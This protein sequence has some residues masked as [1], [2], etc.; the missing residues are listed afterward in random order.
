MPVIKVN[1]GTVVSSFS[2]LPLGS[3]LGEI[4]KV[5][6]LAPRQ[7]GKF[8]QLLISYLVIDGDLTGR[9]QS[10]FLSLS[11]NAMGFVKDFFEKFGL[12]EI[13]D[14]VIDDDSEEL[15]DPDLVGAQVIFKNSQDKKDP[16]RVRV[17]LTSVE[18]WAGS[19]PTVAPTRSAVK[20]PKPLPNQI[21]APDAAAAKAA[22]KAARIAAAEAA[23]AAAAEDDD[24]DEPEAVVEEAPAAKPAAARPATTAAPVRRTL[25]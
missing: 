12:G 19:E 4:T 15:T 20:P 25:R 24:D 9:R 1:L 10:Q 13:P 5:K 7:A 2:D 16:D 6:L 23:L 8:A 14:L 17:T 22:A 11:P 18:E 3:Y 21:E